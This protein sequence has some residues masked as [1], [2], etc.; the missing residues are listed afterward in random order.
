M[1]IKLAG[2]NVPTTQGACPDVASSATSQIAL[3]LATTLWEFLV[4]INP[5]IRRFAFALGVNG[6]EQTAIFLQSYPIP[7]CPKLDVIGT[8]PV[9]ALLDV[10]KM[11]LGWASRFMQFFKR[12]LVTALALIVIGL[13]F[14]WCN[15]RETF[16]IAWLVLMTSGT[17]FDRLPLLMGMVT[18]L[19]FNTT[20]GGMQRV[21]ESNHSFLALK[22]DYS[23]VIGDC[24]GSACQRRQHGKDEYQ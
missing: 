4:G 24:P 19:A 21:I 14:F 2:I 22:G 15:H 8:R 12:V 5:A 18:T 6:L 13:E 10:A 1:T 9:Q 3:V 11:A 16:D 17:R 7:G 20:Y 23:L